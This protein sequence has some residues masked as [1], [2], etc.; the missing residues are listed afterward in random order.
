MGQNP[1]NIIPTCKKMGV[2]HSC[3]VHPLLLSREKNIL[4]TLPVQ[5]HLW[6]KHHC[7]SSRRSESF[8]ATTSGHSTQHRTTSW[9]LLTT[10]SEHS[11]SSSH[12]KTTSMNEL[13]VIQWDDFP[14]AETMET[15]KML[16]RRHRLEGAFWTLLIV[17]VA[18]MF[19]GNW[20]I[21]I[22]Q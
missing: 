11:T 17:V 16:A 12:L 1:I 8:W 5:T 19:F 9:F 15:R 2:I 6:T 18:S 20:V 10:P 13:P 21:S 3:L 7:K 22:S 14:E 4:R